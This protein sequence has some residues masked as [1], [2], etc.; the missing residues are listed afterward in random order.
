MHIVLANQ[1][2]PPESGWGG[3][4]T[5]NYFIARAFRSLGHQVTVLASRT[6]PSQPATQE[7]DGMRIHRLFVR[8]AYRLRRLPF[9]GRYVRPIQQLRYATMVDRV[10]RELHREQP[11]DVIEFAEVNAEGFFYTRTPQTAV[12]VRCHTP[13]FILARYY[14][15]REMQFDTRIIGWCEKDMILRAHARSA[16]SHDMAQTVADATGIPIEK[17][18]VVPNALSLDEFSIQPR[19]QSLSSTVS[20]LFVGRLERVKGVAVLAQAIPK[21][22]ARVPNVRFI[23]AGEELRTASGTS[24]R[25][26]LEAELTSNGVQSHVEFVGAVDHA[27]LMSLYQRADIC[28][29]PSTLYESFSYTCA[30]AMAAGKPVVATR[31]GGIPETVDDGVSG[32]IVSPGNVDELAQAI[33]RLACD[34][35]LREQMGRAGRAKAAR[36]FDAIKVAGKNLAIYERAINYFRAQKRL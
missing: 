16:P 10:L 34:Q 4:A 9:V 28:V 19:P 5:Y 2:F 35:G 30:Q 31:I 11:I 27:T 22:V 25:A 24:Q 33:I 26:E 18:A 1:W 3:V 15:R 7:T 29:V 21:V 23:F 17:F 8:D 13:T 6:N 12:V 32:I 14:D 36:E 20:I